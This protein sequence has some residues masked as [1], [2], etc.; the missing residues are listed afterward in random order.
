MEICS[1]LEKILKYEL[2]KGNKIVRIDENKWTYATLIVNLKNTINIKEIESN[3]AL[4]SFVEYLEN[5]DTHYDFRKT[6][7]CH[8]C[9]HGISTP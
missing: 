3:F 7:F 2:S 9:K 8:E 4:P 5:K 1:H 6:L